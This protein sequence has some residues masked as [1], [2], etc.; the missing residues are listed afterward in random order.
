MKTSLLSILKDEYDY[1][2][3]NSKG[4][5]YAQKIQKNEYKISWDKSAH[6]INCQVR[7]FSPKPGAWTCF[8]NSESR[9]K[10]L[11]A[12]VISDQDIT[13]PGNYE[14]GEITKDFKVKCAQGFLKIEII[15]KEGKKPTSVK[16]FLNG[17]KIIDFF[18]IK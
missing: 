18:F 9:I 8:K 17:N 15:Q 16:D 12:D 14:I 3:Q 4:I 5:T 6:D 2:F 1:K 10:I 11:K 13:G 7:A